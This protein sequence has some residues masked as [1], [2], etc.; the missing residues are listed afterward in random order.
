[1]KILMHYIAVAG[2]IILSFLCY[3]SNFYTL[4]GSDDAVQILMIHNFHL[5]HDLYFWGQDRYGSLVPLIGQ[6]FYRGIGFSPLTSESVTHYLLL[7]AGYFAFAGLFN[8]KFSRFILAIVWFFPPIR[9]IDFLRLNIGEEYSLLAISIFLINQLY[10]KKTEKHRF[11]QHLLLSSITI[12]FILSVWVSDLAAVSVLL[13][14]MLQVYFVLHKND[15]FPGTTLRL[16]P[17]IFYAL[18]GIV[19]GAVFIFYGKYYADKSPSYNSF[20]DLSTILESF[21]MFGDSISELL[22]FKASEP[23]T[24]ASLYLAILLSASLFLLRKKINLHGTQN[25]WFWFFLL[26]TVLIFFIIIIS[27]WSYMN[28]VPRRYFTSNYITFFMALILSLESLTKPDIKKMLQVVLLT[29][30]I[31]AGAGSLY[32]LKYIWPKT[33]KPRIEYVREFESL[34]RIGIIAN[35]WNSYINSA[36]NPD[37]II[38]TPDDRSS[39]R[40][41]DMAREVMKRD[42]LYIIRDGWMDVFPDTLNQFGTPLYKN[43]DEFRMGDCFVCRYRK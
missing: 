42:T 5:P 23:F 43:G 31:I 4:L 32:N 27:K 8:S 13:I 29:A 26:D 36:S 19:V 28:G 7:I 24:S 1:M 39:V 21:R 10:N 3:S 25:K 40:N 37:Q 41:R 17:E 20:N 33:L 34:G 22:M 11:K 18:S 9:L 16:K 6:F 14:L 15:T 30:V 12:L 35:Y 38:A 2:I